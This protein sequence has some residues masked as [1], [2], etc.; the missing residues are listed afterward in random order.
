V[1]GTN[2]EE[3]KGNTPKEEMSCKSSLGDTVK[4]CITVI[5]I[6]DGALSDLIGIG[7]FG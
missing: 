5:Y 4:N 1:T 6:L 3:E 7:I 2:D